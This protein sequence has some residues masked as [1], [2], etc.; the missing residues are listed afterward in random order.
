[1]TRVGVG[2]LLVMG[3]LEKG[4]RFAQRCPNYY[5]DRREFSSVGCVE[6]QI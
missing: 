6:F 3:M 5:N 2:V 4:M 1:M